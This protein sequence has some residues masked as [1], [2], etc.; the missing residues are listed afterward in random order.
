MCSN[1]LFL[2]LST[3]IY[4]IT[5]KFLKIVESYTRFSIIYTK[6]KAH[7]NNIKKKHVA[8]SDTHAKLDETRDYG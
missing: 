7:T 6:L 5:A 3:L 2:I 4:T 1:C 8:L